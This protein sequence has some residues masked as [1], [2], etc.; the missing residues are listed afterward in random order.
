MPPCIICITQI[1]SKEPQQLHDKYCCSKCCLRFLLKTSNFQFS[2]FQ[3]K[4]GQKL[5]SCLY[6]GSATRSRSN[7][8]KYSTLNDTTTKKAKRTASV[9]SRWSRN[10]YKTQVSR[11]FDL[12]FQFSDSLLSGPVKSHLHMIQQQCAQNKKWRTHSGA[13]SGT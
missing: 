4:F 7:S 2:I 13:C 10:N 3:K 5:L 6:V 9:L 12:N 11:R 8:Y 1:K